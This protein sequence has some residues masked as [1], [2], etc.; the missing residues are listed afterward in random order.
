MT[1][2][3]KIKLIKTLLFI[4]FLQQHI[5]KKIS[6]SNTTL[7]IGKVEIKLM[8]V[9]I[10]Y[11][12]LVSILLSTLTVFSRN[13]TTLKE[14]MIRYFSCEVGGNNQQCSLDD[15]DRLSHPFLLTSTYFFI[16][17]LP[18]F[19]LIYVVNVKEIKDTLRKWKR[20]KKRMQSVEL[21]K[22]E[23]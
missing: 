13:F 3:N 17:M 5:Q 6:K 19:N 8:V 12:V 1:S 21:S 18:V 15:I 14:A 23:L 20:T 7:Q 22:L 11:I 2:N 4:I 16:C 9:L 10:Y